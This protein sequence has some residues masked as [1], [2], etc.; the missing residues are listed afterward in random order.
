[1]KYFV[2]FLLPLLHSCTHLYKIHEYEAASF[3]TEWG[4]I[5]ITLANSTQEKISAKPEITV[6]KEPY[7][8]R[9]SFVTKVQEGES[10]KF[11]LLSIEGALSKI[12]VYKFDED[13][14]V[15][16][17][18][19]SV[20]FKKV[21]GEVGVI[22]NVYTSNNDLIFDFSVNISGKVYM[23]SVPVKATYVEERRSNLIDSI[24]SV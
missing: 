1:M 15:R 6:R 18:H 7:S 3:K 5:E 24:M 22:Q 8:F 13:L 11:S 4:V 17:I 12:K 9:V 14:V 2:L 23:H 19:S 21:R 20:T 16:N 10:L